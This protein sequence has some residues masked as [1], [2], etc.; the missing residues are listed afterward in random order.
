MANNIP[1]SEKSKS[2]IYDYPIIKKRTDMAYTEL[3]KYTDDWQKFQQIWMYNYTVRDLLKTGA[4]VSYYVFESSAERKSYKAGQSSHVAMYPNAAAKGVF[5]DIQHTIPDTP[6]FTS[7]FGGDASVTLTWAVP[8]NNE[9]PI[10]SY[11]IT[12]YDI[13]N[14]ITTKLVTSATGSTGL[15]NTVKFTGIVNGISY[16]FTIYA[17][18]DIGNSYTSAFTNAVIPKTIPEQPTAFVVFQE[19][20]YFTTQ[21][22]VPLNGGSAITSYL[23]TLCDAS[24]NILRDV[25]NNIL[26][27]V[28]N[29]ILRDA[30]NNILRDASNNILR[31]VSNN[32][33]RDASNNILR[34]VSNNIIQNIINEEDVLN[35]KQGL[36][37]VTNTGGGQVPYTISN[38]IA[39]NLVIGNYYSFKLLAR[40]A[41]GDSLIT[42]LAAPVRFIKIP[43]QA[44]LWVAGSDVVYNAS[45]DRL[46]FT[47]TQT[48]DDRNMTTS[49]TFSSI[50]VAIERTLSVQNT[51]ST[52]VGGAIQ[53]VASI[54]DIPD[55]TYTFTV[56]A[57]NIATR[58]TDYR[59]SLNSSPVIVSKV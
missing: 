12:S 14:N 13:S 11:T 21:W 47:F 31:D 51:T 23:L 37:V 41:A 2:I 32:I 1:I 48:A 53:V 44:P 36:L 52:N 27:D 24:N 5:N 43:E 19:N 16:R 38:P 10:L 8:A 26:R 9:S 55:N 7:V 25:S 39:S 42:T 40:N 4:N 56:Y 17:T 18:N 6:V 20:N 28:S 22:L 29:N 58:V 59:R 57:Y 49:Y 46:R 3:R 33:L 30:S 54:V 45:E 50:P 15:P 35:T 34:D